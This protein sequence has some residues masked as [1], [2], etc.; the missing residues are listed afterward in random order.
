MRVASAI[1]RLMPNVG[2]PKY[3]ARKLL[4]AVTTAIISYGAPIW[5]PAANVTSYA[6]G[7]VSA[8]RLSSLRVCSAFRTVSEAASNVIAGR[9]PIDL[10]AKKSAAIRDLKKQNFCNSQSIKVVEAQVHQQWQQRWETSD[11]GR[12]TYNLLPSIS[13]WVY[14]KHGEPNYYLTQFLTGHGCFREYLFKYKHVEDALCLFCNGEI[15]NVSHVF[16]SC[17]RF[18]RAREAL[19]GIIGDEVTCVRIVQTMLESKVKWDQINYII[20]AIMQQLRRD[21]RE[22]AQRNND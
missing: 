12:W 4:A 9:L 19:E 7:I 2:G 1:S 17:V 18:T 10:Q 16:T 15:E 21:E 5:F 22:Q 8:H 20:R 14:R 13:E 3:A 6:K 11:K